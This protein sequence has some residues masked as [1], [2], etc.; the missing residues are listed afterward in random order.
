[1]EGKTTAAHDFAAKRITHA[2]QLTLMVIRPAR[3]SVSVGY[4]LVALFNHCDNLAPVCVV[5]IALCE[6]CPCVLCHD[7]LCREVCREKYPIDHFRGEKHIIE[8]DIIVLL[9]LDRWVG[10]R[11]G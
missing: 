10:L 8:G 5:P 9:P 1:M 2:I 4:V 6:S 3:K 11:C 7:S